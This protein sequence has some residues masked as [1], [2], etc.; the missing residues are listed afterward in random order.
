MGTR[1]VDPQPLIFDHAAQFFTVNDSRFGELVNGW[2]ERG[3]VREWQGTVGELQNG[4]QF[5]P[6]PSSPP[7]YIGT[8]GMRPLADSLLFQV[9]KYFQMS[10][11]NT[12]TENK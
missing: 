12:I 5:L 7:R 6:F 8:N 1:V 9:I 10:K 3:L 2:L 11:T 4:G